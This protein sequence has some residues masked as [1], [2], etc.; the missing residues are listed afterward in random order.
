MTFL[1][2]DA[3]RKIFTLL[4]I[5]MFSQK[6]M[7][8]P[9]GEPQ[10]DCKMKRFFVFTLMLLFATTCFLLPNPNAYGYDWDSKHATKFD[11]TVYGSIY[12]TTAFDHA[13]ETASSHFTFYV[14]NDGPGA[15]KMYT[16]AT[17][18][19]FWNGGSVS[20]APREDTAIVEANSARSIYE[21]FSFNLR[22]KRAGRGSISVIGEL[23]VRHIPTNVKLSW[24]TARATTTF[25][26]F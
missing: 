24:P 12:I 2:G 22:N 16:T 5:R 3:F 18:R 17:V 8:A 10:G 15:V 26:L 21:D 25:R 13:T 1:K 6:S 14:S 7:K 19:V 23:D 20:P 9:S 4:V 11:G